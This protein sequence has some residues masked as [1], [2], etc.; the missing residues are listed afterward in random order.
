MTVPPTA[1][2]D[3]YNPLIAEHIGPP[4]APHYVYLL[5]DPFNGDIFYV[6]KGTGDRFRQHGAAAMLLA[7]DASGE[8]VGAKLARIQSIR[9]RGGEPKI[10]FARIRIRTA[11]AAYLVEAALIDVLHRHTSSLTNAVRGHESSA[12]LISLDELEIEL[13]APPLDTTLQ[14]ILIKL[15]WWMPEED[16]ELPRQGFGYRVGMTPRELYDSTRAWWPINQA[17]A[18]SYPY[19]VAVHFGVTRG[20]WEIDQASWRAWDMRVAGRSRTRWAFEGTIPQPDVIDAF[21]G[22]VGRRVPATRTD[23]RALFGSGSPIA[24][25]PA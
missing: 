8:E 1:M 7:D 10:E 17:R 13:L 9:Q 16:K 3:L 24:Y 2:S 15:S 21:I 14:A 4:E 6:G 18:A 5:V 12:G 25:W 20:V 11:E 23:G 22:R 19:A